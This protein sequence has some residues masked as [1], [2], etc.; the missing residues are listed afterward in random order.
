MRFNDEVYSSRTVQAVKGI[1]GHQV[2]KVLIR[3]DCRRLRLTLD[4]GSLLLISIQ[5]DPSGAPHV[6]ADLVRAIHPQPKNV[7]P[8]ATPVEAK[9]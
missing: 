9:R 1:Q 2:Q 3:P 7:D 5:L 4:D 6:D 8:T